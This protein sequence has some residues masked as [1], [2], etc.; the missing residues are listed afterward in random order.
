MSGSHLM[1]ESERDME[2]ELLFNRG[3]RIARQIGFAAGLVQNDM[4]ET[5]ND[6]E[7][8]QTIVRNTKSRLDESIVLMQKWMSDVEKFY[9]EGGHNE[10]QTE[11]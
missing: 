9:S 7:E 1:P 4:A 5:T 3:Q 11:G 2:R 6:S 10:Q 8:L